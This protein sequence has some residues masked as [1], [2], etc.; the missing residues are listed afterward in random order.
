M[1]LEFLPVS[2]YLCQ[3]GFDASRLSRGNELGKGLSCLF[4][5]YNTLDLTFYFL[6]CDLIV[7]T[8]KRSKSAWT[9]QARLH[10]AQNLQQTLWEQV[11]SLM[12]KHA[13]VGS[14]QLRT[15]TAHFLTSFREKRCI[16]THKTHCLAMVVVL[17]GWRG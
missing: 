7:K 9:E 4:Q 15:D 1:L 16:E 2:S 8:R 5:P 10:S 11:A 17:A 3:L 12:S 14:K 13:Q 6:N